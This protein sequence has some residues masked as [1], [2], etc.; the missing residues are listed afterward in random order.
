MAAE[1]GSV[2]ESMLSERQAAHHGDERKEQILE[3]AETVFAENG[4]DAA[5]IAEIATRAGMSQAGMLHHFP[6]KAA[7]LIA[8]LDR[9]D[10]LDA[11]Q[12]QVLDNPGGIAILRGMAM[13]IQANVPHRNET[14]LKLVMAVDASNPAH[15]AH[16]W[17]QQRYLWGC[18]MLAAGF[19][20]DIEAGRV[21]SDLDV[22]S[23]ASAIFAVMDGLKLQWLLDPERVDMGATFGNVVEE[24][25]AA[26]VI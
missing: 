3:A 14:R 5:S 12:I 26:I 13:L 10:D 8:V 15:P 24:M 22:D 1:W 18:R 25:I 16:Q 23:T 20:R 21:R 4:Y 17:A 7:L 11:A 2:A 6:S 9:R 19:Q